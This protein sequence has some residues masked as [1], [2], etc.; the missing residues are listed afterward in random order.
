MK[1]VVATCYGLLVGRPFSQLLIGCNNRENGSGWKYILL[2]SAK[3]SETASSL[4][5]RSASTV[6]RRIQ[7]GH[8]CRMEFSFAYH[9]LEFIEV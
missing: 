8:P 4:D 1:V 7:L 3:K 6:Q 5:A 2:L 9:A